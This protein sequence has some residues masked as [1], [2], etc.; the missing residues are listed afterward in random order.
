M[1]PRL[2]T[3]FLALG[4]FVAVATPLAVRAQ[5]GDAL[6]HAERVCL[7]K[8]IGPNSVTFDACVRR[9]AT[10]YDRAE[11]ALATVEANRVAEAEQACLSYDLDPQTMGYHQCIA[12]ETDRPTWAL[13]Y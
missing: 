9:A 11:P 1:S 7:D 6:A 8:G 2:H 4:A 5:S 3:V 10:A 12:H 13:R